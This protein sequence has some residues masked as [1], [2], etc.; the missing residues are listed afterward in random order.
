MD[1]IKI[2]TLNVNGLK[3]SGKRK[4]ILLF[5]LRRNLDIIFLTETHATISEI[6][7]YEKEWHELTSGSAIFAPTDNPGSGGVAFLFGHNYKKPDTKNKKISIQNR[8]LSCEIK[9]NNKWHKIM[10]TYAPN[11]PTPRK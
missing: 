8:T 9:I 5:L 3:E 2:G 6:P 1:K 4:K 10:V 11:L 7:I